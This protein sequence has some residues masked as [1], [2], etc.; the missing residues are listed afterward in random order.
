MKYVSYIIVF[1]IY[2]CSGIED[3]NDD[4][5]TPMPNPK[6]VFQ[7]PSNFPEITYDLTQNPPTEK[8]F[9]LGKKLF[10]DGKLASD[11][12]VSC[13]FCHIQ[14]FAF[15]HHTHIT[16]HGVDGQIG[17]R[18]AQ[19]LHNLAFME[20]FTWDGAANFLDS[21]FI[22]PITA[23]EE[24]NETISNIIIKLE[25]D[26][27]YPRLFADAFGD[28]EVTTERIFKALSQFIVMMAS[29]N[30]KFDK[31]QRE[32]SVMLTADEDAGRVLF[33]SKCA[34]CHAGTLQTDQ[35]YRNNGL[36][37]DP[38]FQDYGRERVTGLP[39]DRQKFKVP[40]LRNVEMTFP[41]M[42]DG[43]FNSLEDVLD[44]YTD[45]IT[46]SSTLDAQLIMEDSS[47]GLDITDDEKV[48]IILF[49]KTLTDNDFILD[50]RF[51]EF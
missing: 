1:L 11:G 51:S 16:S 48:K 5:Y 23:Q 14:E 33:D 17:E 50:N 20:D 2:S 46:Q 40:S 7:I 6:L 41:Y 45:G 44:F 10:Y 31:W 32:E 12:V 35:S 39:E 43:R 19:P 47:L 9:D 30:S 25:S 3:V 38:E 4:G 15:T 29:A 24:M 27:N 21:Q 49:L 42:H 36:P 13:G 22:I 18:N 8:G 37:L 34:S 28:D 26:E